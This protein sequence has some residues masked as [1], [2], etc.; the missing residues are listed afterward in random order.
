MHAPWRVTIMPMRRRDLLVLILAAGRRGVTGI[1]LTGASAAS[2]PWLSK[3]KREP[4]VGREPLA[5]HILQSV[6]P[7]RIPREERLP[8][9]VPQREIVEL[10][11][12]PLV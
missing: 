7:G 4:L 8:R 5:K 3:P 9:L 12:D 6:D 2:P 11:K 1:G 10:G